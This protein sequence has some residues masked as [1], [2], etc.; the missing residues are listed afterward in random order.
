MALSEIT[1]L[2]NERPSEIEEYWNN[3]YPEIST[4]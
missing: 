3:E 1:W 4:A 2:T